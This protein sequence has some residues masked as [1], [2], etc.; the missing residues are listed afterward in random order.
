MN[1]DTPEFNMRITDNNL[2]VLLDC[3]VSEA[4]INYIVRRINRELI[5]LC[6]NPMPREDELKT[7]LLMTIKSGSP[8]KDQILAQGKAPVPPVDESIKWEKDFSCLGFVVDVENGESDF[9]NLGIQSMVRKN[10]VLARVSLPVTGRE[11]CD[12]FGNPIPVRAPLPLYPGIHPGPNIR[13]VEKNNEL[14]FI[15]TI[16]GSLRWAS[17]VLA[18]DEVRII[19]GNI[20]PRDDHL[21]YPGT[22]VIQ[23]GVCS[24]SKI[25]AG[26]SLEIQGA[27]ESATIRAG[28]HLM[29][30]GGITGSEGRDIKVK[31]G[32]I[33][34]YISE[35]RIE[36]G[37]NIVIRNE[38]VQSMIKTRG[39]VVVPVGRLL[40]GKVM[41]LGG[42]VTA[43]AGSEA[44]VPTELVVAEDYMLGK[45][46][47]PKEEELKTTKDELKQLRKMINKLTAGQDRLSADQQETLTLLFMGKDA[48][49]KDVQKLTAEIRKIRDESRG[50]A[51]SY[52]LVQEV[53]YPG[54]FFRV[55]GAGL[56]VKDVFTTPVKAVLIDKKVVLRE[57]SEKK[58]ED[59]R[60]ILIKQK[61]KEL[62]TSGNFL[63]YLTTSVQK[64]FSTMLG[65]EAEH[66]KPRIASGEGKPGELIAVIELSGPVRGTVAIIFPVDTALAI[67]S[68]MSGIKIT[69][70]DKMVTDGVGEVLN[71]VA[72]T[73]KR[74]LAKDDFPPVD[75]SLPT[76][77]KGNAYVFAS[78]MSKWL[79]LH[80]TSELGTFNLRVTFSADF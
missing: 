11:G 75:I 66:G 54:T 16:K 61:K 3:S 79:E 37:E 55:D 33:T 67:I 72:G 51:G 38:I 39:S 14:E 73:A 23:G 9:S 57:L 13:V 62:V 50:R 69:A 64:L 1:R 20:G 58:A 8:V 63:T 36:A 47:A 24:G 5:S 60:N 48:A 53:L 7:L 26:G 43:Q 19:Y 2:A 76:V 10:Q 70:V 6:V 35:A 29:V 56:R 12:V 40:G 78:S 71:M 68:K 59:T 15:S 52:I 31:G 74:R 25:S 46:L 4:D 30:G 27:L 65:C 41:A 17:G 42:I 28:G 80:F 22:I 45:R 44:H 34:T 49:E 32:V 21:T 18:V 77:V